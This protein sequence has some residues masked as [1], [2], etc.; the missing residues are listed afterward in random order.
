MNT[1]PDSYLS[2]LDGDEY[3]SYL[4]YKKAKQPLD[5]SEVN[6]YKKGFD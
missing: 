5:F 6:L 1:K 4:D 3:C 2:S